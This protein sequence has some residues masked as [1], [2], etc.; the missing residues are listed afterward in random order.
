MVPVGHSFERS[1]SRPLPPTACRACQRSHFGGYDGREERV[2]PDGASWAM[3]L[4]LIVYPSTA[5]GRNAVPLSVA[6]PLNT[7]APTLDWRALSP[8]RQRGSSEILETIAP[9]GKDVV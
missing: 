2:A 3:I 8:L 5:V 6:V 1:S 4:A 7:F 9:V